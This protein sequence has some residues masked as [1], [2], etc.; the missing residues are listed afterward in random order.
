M[1]IARM[2]QLMRTDTSLLYGLRDEGID[3]GELCIAQLDIYTAQNVD[4]IR[5]R[6]PVERR[7]L[8]N[9]KTQ[10]L[11]Q[12]LNCLLRTALCVS[13]VDLIIR[14]FIVDIQITVPEYRYKADLTRLQI[15][16]GNH[17]DIRVRTFSDIHLPDERGKFCFVVNGEKIFVRGTNWVPLDALHSRDA[18]QYE[19]AIKLV[20]DANCNMIRCWGGNV[21]EDT[22]FFD[23]CDENGIMVWQDFAMGCAFYPQRDDFLDQFREEVTS[24]VLKLRNHAS[25]AL[26]AGNNEDDA[27]LFWSRL[28]PFHL[29][30]NRDQVS[31]HVIPEV[32]Y[33]F[34]GTRP[35]LP[36]SP[37]YSEAVWEKGSLEQY[38]P[39]NHLWGPRGYYKDKFYTTAPCTFVSEIGYHGCPN[40]SSLEKMM[41]AEGLY[42][43]TEG[44]QW[45][46]EWITKSTRR[47][48]A[49]GP[50]MDRNNLMLN[51]VNILFG[52]VPD[53]LDEFVFASQSVQAE[54]MKYFVEMWRGRKFERTGII[55]WNVRDGWP[56]ISDAVVDYYGSK[57]L[58]YYF[59]SNVQKNVCVFVNDPVDGAYPLVAVND[60]RHP[61]EGT[62]TVTDVAT[63]R[64][65]FKGSYRVG[66]NGRETIARL[67]VLEGQGMLLIRYEAD[68]ER[69][70]NHYLYGEPP[71]DLKEYRNWLDK[72]KL[73]ANK[74]K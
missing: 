40:R 41:T 19:S 36:S 72:T 67:P 70:G 39:E 34:D 45:N 65:V 63:G 53:D 23:L 27:N 18:A 24:V 61:A 51:Q 25:L 8:G 74:D 21:Y 54:A 22:R 43:W 28:Q 30:P 55:W 58:A 48:V 31:R 62:V 29:D 32:L 71:Y 56:I 38:L 20:T 13:G 4:G 9:V 60:T 15:D 12:R 1:Y 5:N 11:I 47:F 42:P 10:V 6:F 17:V 16:I 2:G 73:Y 57:K 7:I 14:V 46:D 59:L 26:W 66:A 49:W 37:Y 68:G 3:P 69:F 52:S 33:E 50:T 64:E 35:Y 44:R